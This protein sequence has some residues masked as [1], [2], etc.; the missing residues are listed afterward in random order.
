MSLRYGMTRRTGNKTSLPKVSFTKNDR[1]ISVDMDGTI[2]DISKRIK[3]AS[4]FAPNGSPEFYAVLLNGEHYTMDIPIVAAREFLNSYVTQSGGKIVYLSGR[5]QGTESQSEAWLNTHG[6]PPGMIIHRRTGH[7][8]L[9]FKVD[10][11][12]SLKQHTSV[13][14][15]FGDRL[16]DDGGAARSAGL[17]F[18]H[19]KDHVWPST[20]EILSS[21][22]AFS[23]S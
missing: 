12:R 18:I 10:W 8:S 20:E 5:R 4:S 15:H 23:N 16:E 11:L 13:Q 3:Y 6:F 7:R 19:I 21:L 17:R 22:S 14:A 2:A 9:D 1:V